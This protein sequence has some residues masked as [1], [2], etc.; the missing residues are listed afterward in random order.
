MSYANISRSGGS[1]YWCVDAIFGYLKKYKA[2]PKMILALMPDFHRIVTVVNPLV[3]VPYL[4]NNEK[5]GKVFITNQWIWNHYSDVPKYLKRPFAVESSMSR[6]TSM[7]LNLRAIHSLEA[8]CEAAGIKLLWST[9]S[10]DEAELFSNTKKD[11]PDMLEHYI[12]VKTGNWHSVKDN[13]YWDVYHEEPGKF[14]TDFGA[15]G[16]CKDKA[17]CTGIKCHSELEEKYGVNFH[18]GT[19]WLDGTSSSHFGIHKH[20]H[21]AEEFLKEIKSD[22]N[23]RN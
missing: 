19:D 10:P 18:R 22:E 23:F 3:S 15:Y 7:M 14:G 6:E 13:N 8:Y 5:H 2:K 4:K 12:D 16:D 1:P 9:W 20:T 17:N 11:F 21:I